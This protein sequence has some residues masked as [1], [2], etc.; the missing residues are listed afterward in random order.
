VSLWWPC[1]ES[2]AEKLRD[3]SIKELHNFLKFNMENLMDGLG[4][5]WDFAEEQ[6][7]LPEWRRCDEKH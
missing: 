1:R 5:D 3:G 2:I 6:I 7:P 4:Q